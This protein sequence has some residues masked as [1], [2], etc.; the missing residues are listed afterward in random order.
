M[1]GGRMEKAQRPIAVLAAGAEVL[2]FEG[3]TLDLAGRTLSAAG[4]R[5]ISLTPAEFELLSVLIR[6]RGRAL[7]RDQLLDAVAGRRAVP[8][9]RSVDVLIGRLR[10][11]IEPEPKAPRLVLTVPGHGYKFATK[12]VQV[13][14]EQE[15]PA[16]AAQAAEEPATAQDTPA[17]ERRLLTVMVCSLSVATGSPVRLDLE[18]RHSIVRAFRTCCG[19]ISGRLGGVLGTIAGDS[20]HVYFGYPVAHEHDAEQAIRAGLAIVAAAPRLNV[21]S[22]FQIGVCVGIAT[23]E[24]IAGDGLPSEVSGEASALAQE[25]ATCAASGTVVVGATTRLLVGGLFEC[26]ALTAADGKPPGA[27]HVL[28]GATAE[29]RFDALHIGSLTPLAAAEKKPRCCCIAGIWHEQAAATLCYSAA[30]LGLASRDWCGN[31]VINLLTRCT[32]R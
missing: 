31:C 30:S 2:R 9:D 16:M 25:L 17:A 23:G 19:H 15:E 21:G 7:S 14:A 29:T 12:R 8:F 1:K 5:E 6:S 22:A 10:R 3:L 4:G 11:K 24:A 13:V 20:V 27:F 26:C 32:S 18:E 28:G